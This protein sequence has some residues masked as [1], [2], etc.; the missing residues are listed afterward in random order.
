MA[1]K[2]LVQT[3]G[4]IKLKGIVV[5][6]NN[7]NTFREGITKNGDG[8]PWRSVSLTIK[9]NQNNVIYNNDVYG[10]VQEKKVKVYSN[11]DGEK[12]TLEIDFDERNDLPPG[13][14]P[15]GFG[16]VR[17]SFHKA[18]NGKFAAKNYFSYDAVE[19]I[20]NNLEDGKSVWVNAEFDPNTYVSNGETKTTVKYKIMSIGL[21]KEDLD[22]SKEDFKETASFEQEFIVVGTQIVKEQKKVYVTGRLI[23]YNQTWDDITFVIDANKYE[24]LATNVLKK[25]KF[26]DF[27]KAQGIILNGSV[28]EEEQKENS[29]QKFDWGG[30][31][32]E[33]QKKYI[34]NRISELQITNIIEHKEKMYKE[35]DFIKVDPFENEDSQSEDSNNGNDDPWA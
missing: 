5:G 21:L 19:E 7:E 8:V 25:L 30:E 1:N 32:P 14:T 34:K 3:I 13:F 12:K 35:E 15:F 27:V 33:G 26:G 16:T 23:N 4:S 29:K 9:T 28:F 17:T 11:K 31:E 22:F 20:K 24:K 18:E 2:E 6:L 10:Q